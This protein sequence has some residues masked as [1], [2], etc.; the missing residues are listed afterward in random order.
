MVAHAISP[1]T[2]EAK[3]GGFL[4]FEASVLYRVSLGQSGLHKEALS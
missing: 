2:H 3:A 4:E 1:S